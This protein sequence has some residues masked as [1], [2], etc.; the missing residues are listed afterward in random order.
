MDLILQKKV[1]NIID[2]FEKF[3]NLDN[4]SL[5]NKLKSIYK[6]LG[7]ALHPHDRMSEYPAELGFIN[8][9]NSSQDKHFGVLI[10]SEFNQEIQN[11]TTAKLLAIYIEQKLLDAKSFQ[12]ILFVD[13]SLNERKDISNSDFVRLFTAELLM[14]KAKTLETLQQTNDLELIA[15][16]FG[17]TPSFAKKRFEYL[18][19]N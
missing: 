5:A 2:S 13:K 19:L 4:S 15:K 12:L 3:E 18:A 9:E 6:K 7:V 17:V 14:P 16:H 11:V 10:N 1:L 8:F